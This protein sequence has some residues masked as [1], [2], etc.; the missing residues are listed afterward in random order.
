MQSLDAAAA[1]GDDRV[2]QQSRGYVRRNPGRMGHQNNARQPFWT[3]WNQG[4][5]FPVSRQDG[6]NDPAS[7][8]AILE[9]L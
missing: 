1:V 4:I 2:Q 8:K 3:D 7:L 9:R 5:F 6:R